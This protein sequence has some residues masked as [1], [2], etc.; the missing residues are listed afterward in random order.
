MRVVSLVAAAGLV[1]TAHAATPTAPVGRWLTQDRTAIIDI[2]PCGGASLCGRIVGVALDNASDRVPTDY[3][4][5]TQC[6]LTIIRDALPD[7]DAGY[8]GQI[9]DPRNGSSYDAQLRVDDRHR[10]VVRG[11]I[12]IPL[13][14]RSQVWTPFPGAVPSDCHMHGAP[15]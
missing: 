6:G 5:H 2:E 13:L 11:F 3:R 9:Q 7:G 1:A 15:L 8:M 14:G 10:L 4:G 12:G